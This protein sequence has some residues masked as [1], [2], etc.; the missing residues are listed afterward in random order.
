VHELCQL[1]D[2]AGDVRAGG[3]VGELEDVDARGLGDLRELRGAREP[4]GEERFVGGGERGVVGGVGHGGPSTPGE[5][6]KVCARFWGG[7]E[8]AVVV[9]GCDSRAKRILRN[10]GLG[11][12]VCA[13]V[14]TK[15]ADGV[16][17]VG[18][19]VVVIG[20]W[21]AGFLQGLR[22]LLA[23]LT[24][25]RGLRTDATVGDARGLA[26]PTATGCDPYRVGGFGGGM[27]KP[28]PHMEGTTMS[29]RSPKPPWCLL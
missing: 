1:G 17:V 24:A 2:A 19:R 9:W 15:L 16:E 11:L 18:V 7:W 20:R 3:P 22:S 12:G 25:C 21:C 26:L 29:S 5:V 8:G 10:G 14:R 28:A 6:G 23:P 27:R 4:G 13:V